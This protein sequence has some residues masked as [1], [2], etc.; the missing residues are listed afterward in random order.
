LRPASAAP[1]RAPAPPIATVDLRARL[2]PFWDALTSL[3]LTI[4]CLAVLMVLVVSCT[5]AQVHLGTYGAVQKYMRSW[6][7]WWDIPGTV[8]SVPVFPGGALAGMVLAVNLLAAQGRRLELSWKKAG[9]WVVHIGLIL[10]VAG[11]F[12]TGLYQRDNRLSF[13][14]GETTN[15]VFSPREVELAVIDTTDPALDDVYSI[16]GSLLAREGAIEVPG[17]PL[18]IRV[19]RFFENAQL[20][21]LAQGQ[22]AL[23]TAG[24][25]AQVAVQRLAPVTSDDAVNQAAAVVEPVADGRSYGTWLVSSALG[26]PQGFVHEGRSYQLVLRERREYLPYALTLRKFSHDIYPGT[27]IPKNFSSLVHLVNPGAGEARDVLIFMNQPLRYAGKT[28]YQ[29]SFGK[30]DTLS[31]LQVVANPGW[32][33]PYISCVLVTLGLLFHFGISLNRW[34]RRQAARRDGTTTTAAEA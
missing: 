21:R 26:A 23:A 34:L 32:L 13:E 5:L 1:A 14:V 11:E 25:G 24:V 9:L 6:L 29:A 10:L 22:T 18:S 27:D 15:Y 19:K 20:G 30:N 2:E 17:T 12:V 3:K 33:L 28:F 8:L 4:V 7:V 16:P 31:I